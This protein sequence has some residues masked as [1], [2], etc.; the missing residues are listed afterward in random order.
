MPINWA[1]LE[2]RA[3]PG[4]LSVAAA[5]KAVNALP[6]DPDDPN[7]I[8]TLWPPPKQMPTISDVDFGD[9][10]TQTVQIKDLLSSNTWVKRDRL[11]WHVKHPGKR[12]HDN[13][14]TKLPLV[15]A[16]DEGT[17]IID[18]HHTL[19]ARMIAGEATVKVFNLPMVPRTPANTPRSLGGGTF[20]PIL[21]DR[22]IEEQRAPAQPPW[23]QD[24]VDG[25]VAMVQALPVDDD[26]QIDA[27]LPRYKGDD[28]PDDLTIEDWSDATPATVNIADLYGHHKKLNPDR[29]VFHLQN[30]G[31]P[32]AYQ[33]APVDRPCVYK[34]SDGCLAIC[35]GDNRVTAL[36]L[37][38]A[39]TVDVWLLDDADL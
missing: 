27:L 1:S 7:K 35:D 5:V 33:P 22:R 28:D 23:S 15:G 20:V 6:G 11:L 16:V 34:D 21:C 19:A 30:V 3:A 12:L 17:V 4:K 9:V 38:G 36:E 10:T 37:L 24:I 18:G 26:G 25:A 39:T 8:P 32:S 14:F 31:D 29:L 2:S 13:N